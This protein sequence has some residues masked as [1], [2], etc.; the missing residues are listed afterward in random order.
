MLDEM[1]SHELDRVVVPDT[2]APPREDGQLEA[3]RRAVSEVFLI[4]SEH[5]HPQPGITAAFTGRLLLDSEA[6]YEQ[7]DASL[8][9]LNHTPVFREQG[10]VQQVQVMVGRFNPP[11]RPWW[12]N[13]LLFV[14]TVFSLLYVGAVI[15]L[16][17]ALIAEPDRQLTEIWLGWPYALSI[18]LILGAH[19]LGH[20]FAARRHHVPVTLPYFIPL[21]I[22]FFGTLG[23]FIQLRAPMRSRKVLFDVGAAGPLAGLIFAIPILLIGLATAE[24][25][26][27]PVNETYILE[28]NSILYALANVVN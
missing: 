15:A 14:L 9:S 24:V 12:P 11:P 6:A 3:L 26:P 20:Y 23:A 21:P 18:V 17:V 25:R 19:E 2:F 5:P 4:E 22:G 8:A 1:T 27:L 7:L 10:V 28:G 16:G 13:L